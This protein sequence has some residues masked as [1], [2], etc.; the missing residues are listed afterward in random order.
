MSDSAGPSPRL[1]H[2]PQTFLTRFFSQRLQTLLECRDGRAD[3]SLAAVDEQH[4]DR[5]KVELVQRVVHHMRVEVART[6]RGDLDGGNA[7]GANA[8][9]VVEDIFD[10]AAIRQGDAGEIA[11]VVVAEKRS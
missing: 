2:P 3:L 5:L 1:D 4:V 10:V 8:L 9:G 6:A 7:L 11:G